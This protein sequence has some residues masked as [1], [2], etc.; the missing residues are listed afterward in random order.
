MGERR[1][2][3]GVRTGYEQPARCHDRPRGVYQLGWRQG[4]PDI[5]A[6]TVR[7]RA[8]HFAA[9]AWILAALRAGRTLGLSAAV[10][11]SGWG[12]GP[13][14][15]GATPGTQPFPTGPGTVSSSTAAAPKPPR[16]ATTTTGAPANT[17]CSQRSNSSRC[18]TSGTATQRT[19]VVRCRRALPRLPPPH[20]P[21]R[22][23]RSPAILC[24]G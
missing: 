6:G 3:V 22:R 24:P 8:V 13:F 14:G 7:N 16:P 23:M 2:A 10:T 11:A 18:R 9:H 21:N 5:S 17:T 12:T 1:E 20:R 19:R 15:G 4:D